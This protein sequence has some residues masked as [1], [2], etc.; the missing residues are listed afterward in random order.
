VLRRSLGPLAIWTL[1]FVFVT[2]CADASDS[3]AERSM[4]AYLHNMAS[5]DVESAYA[6]LCPSTIDVVT[7]DELAS[8]S[9]AY[10]ADRARDQ[11]TREWG[12]PHVSA[13][14]S[15]EVIFRRTSSYSPAGGPYK[16][17]MI[18]DGN[19]SWLVCPASRALTGI[20]LN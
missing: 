17:R 10:R 16:M 9:A 15:T 2:G 14:G 7:K 4:F 18:L 1:P 6:R 13:D 12:P 20:P 11:R 8:A 19:G 3:G 5:G